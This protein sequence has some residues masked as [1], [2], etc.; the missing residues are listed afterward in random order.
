MAQKTTTCECPNDVS[1][2]RTAQLDSFFSLLLLIC[3]LGTFLLNIQCI[4][5]QLLQTFTSKGQRS[6]WG[7]GLS[8][9][10]GPSNARPSGKTP[11]ILLVQCLSPAEESGGQEH[12][13]RR[14][15]VA[16]GSRAY[17][18]N[19][20]TEGRVSPALWLGEGY[21]DDKGKHFLRGGAR[22]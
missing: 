18:G 4:R 6:P 21:F 12:K 7:E 5:H 1:L 8:H 22:H 13:T 19:I 14:K 9:S 10:T 20:S 16:L 17:F 3:V 2:L 11:G 15:E